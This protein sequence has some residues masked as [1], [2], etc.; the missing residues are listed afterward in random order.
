MNAARWFESQGVRLLAEGDALT[1]EGLAA[2]APEQAA[3][4]VAFARQNK[5]RLLEE[6]GA[7]QRLPW[8]AP[9][10]G[11]IDTATPAGRYA[12]LFA[13]AA[14]YGA[15]LTKK[16]GGELALIC[17]AAMPPEAAQAAQDGLAELAGYIGGRLPANNRS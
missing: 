8:P 7:S 13:I 2:L 9:E 3:E 4:V 16:A 1:L 17:S 11:Q 5:A 6:L 14:V 10:S 12:C 15:G